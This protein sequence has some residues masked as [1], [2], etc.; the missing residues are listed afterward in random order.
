MR[1]RSRWFRWQRFWFR[2]SSV[3]TA[4]GVRF[5][6][7]YVFPHVSDGTSR[8]VGRLGTYEV[9]MFG[10]KESARMVVFEAGLKTLAYMSL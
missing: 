9:S 8:L 4:P 2:L 1:W 5:W 3:L 7:F 6:R 10:D